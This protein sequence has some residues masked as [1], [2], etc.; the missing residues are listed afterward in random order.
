MTY[1]V[2]F[3]IVIYAKPIIALFAEY[4]LNYNEGVPTCTLKEMRALLM[5]H[6][7]NILAVT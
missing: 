4:C 7:N 5:R 2:D 3:E 1:S 6:Y